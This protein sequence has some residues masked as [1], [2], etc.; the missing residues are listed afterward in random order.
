MSDR[1]REQAEY[2]ARPDRQRGSADSGPSAHPHPTGS[3]LTDAFDAALAQGN[4]HAARRLLYE[5]EMET[6]LPRWWLSLG[7]ARIARA[8]GDL[9]AATAILVMAMEAAPQ[10]QALRRFM[11]EILLAKGSAGH[12][13]D[14]LAHLGQPPT[15]YDL[16]GTPVPAGTRDRA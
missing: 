1:A 7:K 6:D 12:A 10:A 16:D 2:A 14:V 4:L 13:R 15:E 11:T 8:D 5:A 3:A 9:E